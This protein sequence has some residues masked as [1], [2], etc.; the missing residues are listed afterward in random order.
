M[1]KAGSNYKKPASK[2]AFNK[3]DIL[4]TSILV[5][6]VVIVIVVFSIAVSRD[7]FIRSKDGVLQSESNWLIGEYAKNNASGYYKLGEIGEMENLYT[8]ETNGSTIVYMMPSSEESTIAMAYAGTSN[9]N[10]AE[11]ADALVLDCET[12]FGIEEIVP[13]EM[14]VSGKDALFIYAAPAETAADETAADETA[15]EEAP[16]EETADDHEHTDEEAAEH[17]EDDGHDHSDETE[18]A[19]N[20][21]VAY[22]LVDYDEDHCVLVELSCTAETTEEEARAAID[23]IAAAITLEDR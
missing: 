7:D 23:E 22:L 5:A 19:V 13:A 15:T 4:Y 16:A 11:F 2:K 20:V 9:V 12:S 3:K 21:P 8:V 1:G 18:E 14:T 17:T 10:Y 6:V